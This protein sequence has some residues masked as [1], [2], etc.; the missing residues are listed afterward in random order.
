MLENEIWK[1]IPGYENFYQV[2]NTGKVK[3]LLRTVNKSNG[4]KQTM[5]EKIM[6]NNFD[7]EYFSVQL[8]RDWIAK[9]CKIHKL[10]VL[11]FIPEDC[12]RTC[13]NHIDGNKLN[14]H[15]NNLERC[16]ISEN[17]KHAI[18]TGLL[19]MPNIN[20]SNNGR[21]KL[22]ADQVIEIREL[23][24]KIRQYEIAEKFGIKPAQI[25][26]II[27]RKTWTHI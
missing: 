25:S 26:A 20:G 17:S 18:K 13:V 22:T 8:Q 1:D 12:N 15:L 27:N 2:S 10:V 6:S 3:S 11:C 9:R 23:N 14:N 24:G 16:T 19:I 21:S 5:P 7:G 4:R